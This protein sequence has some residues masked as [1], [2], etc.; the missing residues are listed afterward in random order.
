MRNTK[1]YK[2][3]FSV[4]DVNGVGLETILKAFEK[5]KLYRNFIAILYAPAN[6]VKYTSEVMG[7]K[8]KLNLISNEGEAKPKFLNIISKDLP[9][10]EI[11]FGK[12]NI[13]AGKLA[14]KSLE[15]AAKSVKEGKC[16]A[17]VTAPINKDNIQS[18]DFKF[19]GHTEYLE[20][21]WEGKSL[22]FMVHPQL[23]VGLVT[24]H[25]PIREVGQNISK[26]RIIAKL[27]VIIDSLKKDFGVL[28]PKVAVLGLNPHAG[29]NGLLGREE[30]EIIIPSIQE[31]IDK[32]NIVFGPYP[33]DS[34]FS[35]K[36][37]SVFD[38]VLA[39]YHD[40]GLMPFKTLAG[41]EGVN[42]TAGLQFVRVSPDHGVAYD[43][44]GKNIADD[45][46]MVEAIEMAIEI[47][48]N[49]EA[50]EI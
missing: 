25:L 29:D 6:V 39:M 46:S 13:G 34:F 5:L 20:S 37:I 3:A 22:M 43:L 1:N 31:M 11:D 14:F 38:A 40:Q 17:L 19:P 18:A 15:K 4:G 42:F 24:N 32:K 44:A 49:R 50:I 26:E 23:K 30:K 9:S 7:V 47:L 33:A 8:S 35:D 27:E 16:D 28:K 36:N 10:I 12:S 41:L 48:E 21:I 45:T 2:I